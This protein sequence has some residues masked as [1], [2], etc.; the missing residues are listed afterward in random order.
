MPTGDE[1][2]L[3]LS[4]QFNES[5]KYVYAYSS[6]DVL[7]IFNTESG[8]LVSMLKFGNEKAMEV[9]GNIACLEGGCSSLCIY[10]KELLIKLI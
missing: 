8:K 1:K 3:L 7:H 5:G 10:S 4:A 6:N 9:R 2:E